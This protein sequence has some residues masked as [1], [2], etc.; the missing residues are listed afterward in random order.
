M[1]HNKI[2]F[3][4]CINDEL[5]YAESLKYLQ[6]LYI[7]NGFEVD[8]IAVTDAKSMTEGYNGAM[9][10]SDAKYK[11][12]LHQDVF[13]VNKNFISDVVSLFT[14]DDSLGL[15]GVVG[16]KTLPLDGMWWKSSR[17]YGKLLD[18]RRTGRME[19]YT[20][21]EVLGNYEKVQAV[22]GP[23]LVTQYDVEW[24]EDLLSGW[25]LYDASQSLEFQ[26]A[27]Y[28]V[29]VVAQIEP[30]CVHDCG[31]QKVGFVVEQRSSFL[32]EYEDELWPF[33]KGLEGKYP[34]VS[35]LILAYNQ[36]NYLKEA[37]ESALDQTYPNIE[38]I[39]G[40]DSTNDM[41]KEFIMPYLG[42]YK[43]I[44]YFKNV[45]TKPDYGYQNLVNCLKRSRGDY[46]NY[47][48]HDDIFHSEKIERMM[49]SFKDNPDIRLVT[50]FR[51]PIDEDGNAIPPR[52]PYTKIFEEDTLI[53]GYALSRL[54]I[55]KLMNFIGEQTT[56][57][58]KKKYID[59]NKL[60]YFN[61]VRFRNIGDLATWFTLLQHGDAVYI[62]DPLS[63]FRF[64]SKQNSSNPNVLSLGMN[65]WFNLIK[66]S[67]VKGILQTTDEY[68]KA[69]NFW[70]S[71]YVPIPEYFLRIADGETRGQLAT[72]FK[73]AIDIILFQTA[74]EK[75]ECPVCNQKLERFLPYRYKK[76]KNDY[77]AQFQT[78][79]SDVDNFTCPNCRCHD[80]TRHLMIY[81]N[82]LNVWD[83]CIVNKKILHIAPEQHLRQKINEHNPMEYICGDLYPA[84]E[85]IQKIDIT[86]TKFE[87]N[88]F[89]FIM[90]NHVLEH[91]PDDSKAMKEFYRILKK[92]G[93]AV[94]Q[95]PYSPILKDSF[96]DQTK[97]S[98]HE[99]K[100]FFGQKDHV[101]VYGLDLFERLQSAGF[102]LK[103]V[104]ND[105]LFS[106]EESR[107]YGVN[108]REDLILVEK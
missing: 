95:T 96:E 88:Y 29:G 17:T 45:K 9:R 68:K 102:T 37:L 74:D 58:F 73:E 93:K 106:R 10:Q 69:L 54:V 101:R 82:K 44:T 43:H 3:I 80:R 27:G 14:Q 105:E 11:V 5:L 41:V 67:Y 12:Y 57:L 50:S 39:I 35:I 63:S 103:I 33:E 108:E 18:N 48:F 1:N 24:R 23:I 20:Y 99:R 94:L 13:I 98:E 72:C 55:S 4:Y 79:G 83:E 59:E 30:W 42:K 26:R 91:V 100:H 104:K 51:Q 25:D 78:I 60:G 22:G 52:G 85:T 46:I 76:H 90:C 36:T 64:H 7:P 71:K 92:G 87:D 86:N 31:R 107:K 38:I 40:D 81:F 53:S 2:C 34:L 21:G 89:D 84:N 15:L 70:M 75:C 47:L 6:S 49:R 62:S 77:T 66:H 56:V 97:T 16:S 28:N 61:E 65:A 19:S 32:N 8:V